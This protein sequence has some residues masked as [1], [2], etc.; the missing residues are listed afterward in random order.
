MLL[1]DR[2]WLSRPAFASTT[3]GKGVW[4]SGDGWLWAKLLLLFLLPGGVSRAMVSGE[5]ATNF[6]CGC[7]AFASRWSSLWGNHLADML[8]TEESI[9][10]LVDLCLRFVWILTSVY[11]CS[12]CPCR[13]LICHHEGF[14]SPPDPWILVVDRA[15][16]PWKPSP[17]TSI[18]CLRLICEL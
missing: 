11:Q 15:G 3:R 14:D 2:L 13:F 5:L 17:C 10:I 6:R 18:A 8:S 4:W 16:H 1:A 9:T 12:F 7:L